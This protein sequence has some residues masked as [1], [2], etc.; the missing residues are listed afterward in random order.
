MNRKSFCW[1]AFFSAAFVSVC[2]SIPRRSWAEDKDVPGRQLLAPPDRAK[3]PD[4]KPAALPIDFFLG[5]RIAFV[6][7]SLAEK[8]NLYGFFEAKLHAAFPDKRLTVRNFARPAD[9]VTIRQRP[10]NYA[11]LDDPLYH[12]SPDTVFC[13]FGFNESCA[14]ESETEAFVR[15]YVSFLEQFAER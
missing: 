13:F 10:G 7:N 12:F 3:R 5:E 4:L 15:S 1:L 8:M 14:G 11:L 6:G 9:E 2:V